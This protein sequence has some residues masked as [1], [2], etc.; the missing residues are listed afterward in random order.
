MIACDRLVEI[1]STDRRYELHGSLSGDKAF[2]S[3]AVCVCG[4]RPRK[5]PFL[6]LYFSRGAL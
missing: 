2:Q 4:I 3:D 5:R 1:D 6:F